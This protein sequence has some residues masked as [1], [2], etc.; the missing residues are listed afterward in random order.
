MGFTSK[1][2]DQNRNQSKSVELP[3]DFYRAEFK[4]ANAY[5]KDE[6]RRLALIFEVDYEGERVEVGRFLT[7]KAT[8]YSEGLKEDSQVSDS[9]LGSLFDRCGLLKALQIEISSRLQTLE[10][11]DGEVPD[12]FL[13]E[14]EGGFDA[15]TD[16]EHDLL[17]ECIDAQL[18]G[19]EFKILAVN[20]EGDGGSLVEDIDPVEGHDYES[21]REFS[22]A[23]EEDAVSD[24][25][26]EQSSSEDS[27]EDILFDDESDALDDQKDTLSA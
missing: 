22:G 3:K 2:S 24:E 18:R 17:A 14:K 7:A 15:T 19:H 4:E 16:N 27:D 12:G 20:P 5:V 9:D 25:S 1:D 8:T 13:T 6:D 26:D 23:V 11:F 10:W 21:D